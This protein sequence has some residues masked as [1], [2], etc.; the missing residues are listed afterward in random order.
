MSLVV[1][2]ASQ[3]VKQQTE[4]VLLSTLPRILLYS[5]E[6]IKHMLCYMIEWKPDER[7]RHRAVQFT[8]RI[9]HNHQVR[10]ISMVRESSSEQHSTQ[11]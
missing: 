8:Q 4:D 5:L 7:I 11:L 10:A 2:I 9:L 3:P 6:H 1:T